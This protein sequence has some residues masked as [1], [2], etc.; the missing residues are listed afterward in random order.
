MGSQQCFADGGTTDCTDVGLI[1]SNSLM[2]GT[3][4]EFAL[5]S[6]SNSQPNSGSYGPFKV[7][8]QATMDKDFTPVYDFNGA[9]GYVQTGSAIA[10]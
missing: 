7:S 1:L 8:T 9:F 2:A 6:T 3:P 10:A 4:Y 5:S